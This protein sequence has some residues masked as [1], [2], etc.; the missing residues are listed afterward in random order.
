[1]ASRPALFHVASVAMS[2]CTTAV[3]LFYAASLFITGVD[4]GLPNPGAATSGNLGL[5]KDVVPG[6]VKVSA[7][8]TCD[9]LAISAVSG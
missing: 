8:D 3:M 1:M 9:V 6:V 2:R 7:L 4:H 5:G